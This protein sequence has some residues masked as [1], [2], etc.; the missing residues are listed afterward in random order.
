[1]S[2]V[3]SEMTRSGCGAVLR[4]GRPVLDRARC[5]CVLGV[6]P[7][8]VARAEHA[9]RSS[10]TAAGVAGGYLARSIRREP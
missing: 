6:Q 10:G 1:M 9:R 3:S 7:E 2:A 5:Q 4:P 8:G